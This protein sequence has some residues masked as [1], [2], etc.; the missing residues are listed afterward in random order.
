[1]A[2][3][4]LY[5]S[6]CPVFSVC[7]VPPLLF[8]PLVLLLLVPLPRVAVIYAE[9]LTGGLQH[10]VVFCIANRTELMGILLSSRPVQLLPPVS[11]VLA[12]ACL[13]QVSTKATSTSS[14]IVQ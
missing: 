14:Q 7:W 9:L 13:L 1:M 2:A 12:S 6:S 3:G 5:S 8:P 11:T 4:A 10:V